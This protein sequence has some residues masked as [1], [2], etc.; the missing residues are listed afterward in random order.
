MEKSI[1]YNAAVRRAGTQE[2]DPD[3]Y[4]D[5]QAWRNTF[6]YSEC[7]SAVP[8]ANDGVIT[9][10]ITYYRSLK[11]TQKR[12]VKALAECGYVRSRVE[13]DEEDEEDYVEEEGERYQ[14]K[15]V[16]GAVIGEIVCLFFKEEST[17]MTI[18]EIATSDTDTI[19]TAFRTN[20]VDGTGCIILHNMTTNPVQSTSSRDLSVRITS[21]HDSPVEGVETGGLGTLFELIDSNATAYIPT[22]PVRP[23][24]SDASDA[25]DYPEIV[26]VDDNVIG[27][28]LLSYRDGSWSSTTGPTFEYITTRRD[29]F[30]EQPRLICQILFDC[31]EKWFV[32][33]WTVDT[34]D[35]MRVLKATQILNEIVDAKPS[36]R[37]G[38]AGGFISGFEFFYK[39]AGFSAETGFGAMG[40]FT[41]GRDQNEEASRSYPPSFS[42]IAL[43]TCGEKQKG[44]RACE[45][46]GAVEDAPRQFKACAACGMS[47]YC[48]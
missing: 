22:A 7:G 18:V 43:P 8:I 26:H 20:L 48:R 29:C 5:W 24:A 21:G 25:S 39:Y 17:Y 14:K 34:V 2:N 36:K 4:A 47:F 42:N 45:C 28:C 31:V 44:L 23:D 16:D 6:T 3:K 38:R 11:S 15:G 27:R 19:K 37:D 41:Q 9:A 1:A 10:F 46:C 12:I 40:I 33:T 35:T 30:G 32:D 13:I